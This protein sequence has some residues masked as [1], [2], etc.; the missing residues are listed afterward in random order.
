MEARVIS[1]PHHACDDAPLLVVLAPKHR[2][3][4]LNNVEQLRHNLMYVYVFRFVIVC[5]LRFCADRSLWPT[6]GTPPAARTAARLPSSCTTQATSVQQEATP[7]QKKTHRRDAPEKVGPRAAAQRQLQP[8]HLH[9]RLV[10]IRVRALAADHVA[11]V[12]CR[13]LHC[14]LRR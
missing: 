13:A 10:G 1:P 4:R 2:H 6:V 9:K 11:R 12:P 3:V 7:K 5:D 8:L 14:V